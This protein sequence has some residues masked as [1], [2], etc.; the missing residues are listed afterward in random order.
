MSQRL[1]GKTAIVTGASSGIGRA[2]AL[3]LGREGASLMVGYYDGE[4]EAAASVVA[5]VRKGSG[6]AISQHTDVSKPDEV[7]HLVRETVA[8]FG[9]VDVL[10]ANAGVCPWHSFLELPVDVW[11][12]TQA[13]N[14]RGTFLCCQAVARQMVFQRTGGS[15]VAIGSVGAYTGGPLQVHY[16]ASKAAVGALMRSM[17]VALGPH[18]I[19][20]NTILP[21]CIATAM[22][23]QQLD[24]SE[25]TRRIA[26]A[27]PLGR[28]GRP[29]D[30]AGAVVFLASDESLFCT[31]A[32]LR[33]D[34]GIAINV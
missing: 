23:A 27:T 14:H 18:G 7:E 21:G 12:R 16:N 30:I 33:V 20:C 22:N 17:A 31:G 11:E 8:T 3:A 5:D 13:V 4:D 2:I 15:I 25:Q 34:G 9:R 28:I 19:R 24:D 26:S 29:E 1:P 10:V 6:H 32:E